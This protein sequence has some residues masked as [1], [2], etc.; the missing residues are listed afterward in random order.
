MTGIATN[1]RANSRTRSSRPIKFASHSTVNQLPPARVLR[2]PERGFLRPRWRTKHYISR[3]EFLWPNSVMLQSALSRADAI[4]RSEGSL[5]L[6]MRSTVFSIGDATASAYLPSTAYNLKLIKLGQVSTSAP[7]GSH[8]YRSQ[9][10]FRHKSSPCVQLL[11]RSAYEPMLLMENE[12]G[13]E[14]TKSFISDISLSTS[15][16]NWMMKSTNLCLSISSVWV[17]VIR[18]EISY[19]Y[20]CQRIDSPGRHLQPTLTGFRRRMKKDSALCVRKRVNLWTRM[21]SI[22]SACLILMLTRTLLTLGSMR[23]FSFSLRATVKGFNRTSG[24]LWASISGTLCRSD[25][26]EAKFERD[27]AAVREERTH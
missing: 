23:T 2:I 7:K 27:K 4:S 12:R 21:F 10:G 11:K 20:T 6:A 25:A 8:A 1:E 18:K 9:E 15:S 13:A 3:D 17:F 5:S 16:M 19:P 26:C 24:E 22:S 14:L